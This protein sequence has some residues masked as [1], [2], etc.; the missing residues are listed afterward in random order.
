M[1]GGNS[2]MIEYKDYEK[3]IHTVAHKF[4]G[5]LSYETLIAEGNV[6]FAE[7]LKTYDEDKKTTF[8]TYLFHCLKNKYIGM[9]HA[10][11]YL[12]NTK[13]SFDLDENNIM[14]QM[15]YKENNNFLFKFIDLSNEAREIAS[16]IINTPSDLIRM[17]PKPYL[18]KYKI[19]QYLRSKGWKKK[20]ILKAFNEIKNIL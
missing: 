19:Q 13:V 3:V 5:K 4:K 15:D 18:S 10:Q 16:L 7:C 9:L 11:T 8:Q 20:T 12:K 2:M 6:V 14:R 17:L 1:T